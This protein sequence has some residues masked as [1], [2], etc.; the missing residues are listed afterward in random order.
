VV[1]A[2][3]YLGQTVA[4][5]TRGLFSCPLPR[6]KYFLTHFAEFEAYGEVHG[7][8]G[9]ACQ[10][11]MARTAIWRTGFR[12][13]VSSVLQYRCQ[14]RCKITCTLRIAHEPPHDRPSPLL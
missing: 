14:E 11:L 8:L 4:E 1:I 12:S 6:R 5:L 13:G 9:G 3:K 2:F 10:L 7:R